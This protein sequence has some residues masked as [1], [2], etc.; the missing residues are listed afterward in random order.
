MNI[1]NR[2]TLLG[3]RF[4]PWTKKVSTYR[5]ALLDLDSESKQIPPS[6]WVC[7]GIIV[8]FFLIKKFLIKCWSYIYFPY[9]KQ[10]LIISYR[11]RVG[12]NFTFTM[13]LSQNENIQKVLIKKNNLIW[14]HSPSKLHPHNRFMCARTRAE[15]KFIIVNLIFD[16]FV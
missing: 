13:D 10:F 16:Y 11:F 8:W 15:I 7:L 4:L 1:H 3:T 2:W 9:F 12:L 5:K 6:Q 14:N